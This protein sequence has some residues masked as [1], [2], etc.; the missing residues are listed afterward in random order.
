MPIS[1]DYDYRHYFVIYLINKKVETGN[2][3]ETKE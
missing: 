1:P 2:L 3:V